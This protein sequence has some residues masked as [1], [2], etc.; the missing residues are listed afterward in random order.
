[1]NKFNKIIFVSENGAA[2]PHMAAQIMRRDYR[3]NDIIIRSKGLVVL[4]PEPINEKAEAVMVSNG[5]DVKGLIAEPLLAE[6]IDDNTLIV[7]MNERQKNKVIA[8]FGHEENVYIL[9]ELVGEKG[10]VLDPYGGPLTGYGKCFED[11]EEM[12]GK[13][14]QSLKMEDK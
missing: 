13:F 2:R 6:E 7:V 10:D 14:I 5:L 11:I 12:I 1:M 8:D 3:K 4:F 9:T